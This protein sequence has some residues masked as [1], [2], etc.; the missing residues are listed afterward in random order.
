MLSNQY[1]IQ[2]QNANRF[3]LSIH[4]RIWYLW[5]IECKFGCIFIHIFTFVYQRIPTNIE[6]SCTEFMVN[7]K[8]LEVPVKPFHSTF[9]L[10]TRTCI[11]LFTIFVSSSSTSSV[12][13]ECIK[14][15]VFFEEYKKAGIVENPREIVSNSFPPRSSPL[16]SPS[17]SLFPPN[18]CEMHLW[19]FRITCVA[20]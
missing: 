10:S 9:D 11:I 17:N 2:L 12:R 6:N 19:V 5:T 3:I 4:V 8:I 7:E 18:Q 20:R 15:D 14:C 16:A 1:L 13:I